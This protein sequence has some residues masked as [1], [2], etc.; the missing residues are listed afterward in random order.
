MDRAT[1]AAESPSILMAR[2]SEFIAT[3]T[4]NR[5]HRHNALDHAAWA[6]LA[7]TFRTLAGD[8]TVRCIIIFGR[9][10]K[11]FSSGADII[12]FETVRKTR[13]QAVVYGNHVADTWNAIIDCPHPIIAAIDGI[14]VGGGLELACLADMRI[15]STKSRFGMPLKN[16]GLVLA[17]PELKPIFDVAGAVNTL[18]ILLEGR[19]FGA[20]E[21]R[22]RFRLV[23]RVVAD[24][25]V[26]SEAMKLAATISAGAPLSARW[27]KKFIRRLMQPEPLSAADRAEAFECFDTQDFLTGYSAFLNKSKPTFTGR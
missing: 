6:S 7:D 11:A 5:P 27:H 24:G 13:E 18:E 25:E 19:I 21:A 8:E 1:S 9:G 20:D 16:L 12:E 14:C 17:Y 2:P 4:L 23:N 22:D 3:V 26:E 10:G 15:A